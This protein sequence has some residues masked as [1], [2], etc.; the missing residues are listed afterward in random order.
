MI[1]CSTNSELQ[2]IL[3]IKEAP[4]FV[5]T[6]GNLHAGHLSL[7]KQS[8]TENAVTVIS[9]FVNPK[10]FGPTED[11]DSYPRTLEQDQKK[12]S[13][14]QQQFPHK[15]LVIFHPQSAQ[16][17]FQVPNKTRSWPQLEP[18]MT[19]LEG[20]SRPT[21]F[22]GVLAVIEELFS[23]VQPEVAYFGEK[24]F[25][26][27][28]LIKEMVKLLSLS[29]SI[30]A[31]PLVRDQD[32]LALSS[33][34]QYLSNEQREKVLTLPHTLEHLQ[35]I[36]QKGGVALFQ[37]KRQALLKQ[38]PAWDYLDFRDAQTFDFPNQKTAH[39]VLLGA[40]RAGQIRLLDNRIF[41][42]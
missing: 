14:L 29:V 35:K 36:M 11:L 42:L 3:A 16:E 18:L 17:V 15:E 20:K 38:D 39:Y 23:I 28:F 10:Q 33:R 22:Q 40:Y 8:L 7:V 21:H 2:K 32:G 19:I 25:Q 34:N 37:E 9:L 31:M 24:D 6:M 4:G 41:H 5:P 27:L 1:T 30:K 12:L 13:Q 26:Q